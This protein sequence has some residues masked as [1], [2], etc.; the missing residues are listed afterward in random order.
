[1]RNYDEIVEDIVTAKTTTEKQ[2][3]SAELDAANEELASAHL[4][5]GNIPAYQWMIGAVKQ[6]KY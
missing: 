1:M 3:Y 5:S 2:K 6:A 4:A